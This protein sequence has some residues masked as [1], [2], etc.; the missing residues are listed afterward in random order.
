MHSNLLSEYKVVSPISLHLL[1]A[2][3]LFGY[4][5]K[6]KYASAKLYYTY[7]SKF[8]LY[9]SYK[10]QTK[11]RFSLMFCIKMFWYIKRNGATYFSWHI[12]MR[13]NYSSWSDLPRDTVW[14]GSVSLWVGDKLPL[15]EVISG[16]WTTQP[17]L[18]IT[19]M[20]GGD[21]EERHNYPPEG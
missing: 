4:I 9:I 20:K 10:K 15:N 8:P 12:H 14:Y 5:I 1:S 3:L 21:K 2:L 7:Q 6:T 18:S 19:Q 16:E 11:K 13:L 17:K